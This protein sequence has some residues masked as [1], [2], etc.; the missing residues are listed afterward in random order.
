MRQ[1]WE[2][3][4]AM[5]LGRETPPIP[6]LDL[7]ALSKIA[8]SSPAVLT[9]FRNFNE[10]RDYGEQIRPFNFLL[11]AHVAP[12]G[13]PT[14]C[15]PKRFHLIAKYEPDPSKWLA[16]SWI[17]RY[18]GRRVPVTI[19]GNAPP[20]YAQLKSYRQVLATFRVHPERKSADADGKACG[21]ETRGL[22]RRRPVIGEGVEYSGKESHRYEEVEKGLIHD[23]S[24]VELS[25]GSDE[26]ERFRSRLHNFPARQ[27]AAVAGV[28]VRSIRFYRAGREPSDELKQRLLD[29]FRCV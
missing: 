7:P 17:D 15:D 3:V 21:P 28:S 19:E 13:H 12:F 27:L 18:S 23:A 26:W 24:E 5:E 22:L 16:L 2:L 11:S 1:A 14:W 20:G 6:W 29:F 9:P 8:V 10:G 4:L 25:Y